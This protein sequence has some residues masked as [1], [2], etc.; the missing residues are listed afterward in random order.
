MYTYSDIFKNKKKILFITAHPDDVDVFFGGTLARLNADQKETHVLI[1]TSGGRGSKDKNISEKNLGEIRVKEELEALKILG[2]NPKKVYFLNYL[3]G[4]VEN[5][6]KLIGDISRYLRIIKPDIVCTHEPHGYY[7]SYLDGKTSYIN[8][9]DHRITGISVI[10]AIYPFSRD[11]SFFPEHQNISLKPHSVYEI[12][13]TGNY[14]QNTQIAIDA[15]KEKKKQALLSHKSQ[16]NTQDINDIMEESL[17]KIKNKYFE[18][19][20]YLKLAW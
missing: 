4:E 7:Y 12:L 20:N 3:D 10:D 5:N 18:A 6:L 17:L 11:L 9:R 19:F 2:Q 15:F 16:F 13:L 8:H 14:K 1:V